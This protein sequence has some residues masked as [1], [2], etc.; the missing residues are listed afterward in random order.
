MKVY[1]MTPEEKYSSLFAQLANLCEEEGW[2][3]PFSYARSREILAACKLGHQVAKDYSGADAINQLGQGVEYKS[4][5]AKH[6]RGTYTGISVHPTWEEQEYYLR[7]EKIGK[8]KEHYYNRFDQGIMA[9]SWKLTGQ[10]AL[11]I[12]LPKLKK[13]Y[14]NPNR[15]NRKDPRL[16]CNIC[17]TEIKKHGEKVL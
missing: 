5:I 17:W 14:H 7:E 10:K 6:P 15:K 1:E 16:A 8:Y 12:L 3:D 9:E 13:Q 2:G 11:E 4:T